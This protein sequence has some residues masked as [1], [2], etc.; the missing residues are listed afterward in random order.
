MVLMC[1]PALLEKDLT[2][3]VIVVTG[4]NSGI[5]LVTCRQLAKQGATVVLCCR[6]VAAGEEAKAT[7][8]GVVDVMELDLVDLASVKAFCDAFTKKYAKLDVL[9]NNAGVMNTPAGKTKQGFE[10]QFGIN[11]MGHFALTQRL[12]PCLKKAAPSRVICVSSVAAENV[13][14]NPAKIDLDDLNFETHEYQGWV[15]YG[16]AKLANYF[17]AKELCVRYGEAGI[18][19]CS[20]HPGFVRSN[21]INHTLPSCMQMLMSP[22]MVFAMGMIEPWEGTQTSLHCILTDAI[23]PGAFYSCGPG[24]PA[25]TQGGWPRPLD[26]PVRENAELSKRLWEVSEKLLADKGFA[27]EADASGNIHF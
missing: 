18:T 23:E 24:S 21:L 20:L 2:G 16:Q 7:M 1:D 10:T 8:T 17:M 9:V 3:K 19:A 4:G 26:N 15:A 14:G 5:G 27:V 25:G 22:L 12:L 11:H 6:R 13:N